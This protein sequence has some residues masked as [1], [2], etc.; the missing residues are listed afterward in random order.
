MDK[1]LEIN[2]QTTIKVN[3]INDENIQQNKFNDNVANVNKQIDKEKLLLEKDNAI[4]AFKEQLKMQD[5]F[6]V[7][8]NEEDIYQGSLQVE[9]IQEE[10]KKLEELEELEKR[11]IEFEKKLNSGKDMTAVSKEIIEGYIKNEY[12]DIEK[13][14]LNI[15]NRQEFIKENI[16][17]NVQTLNE[18]I[19]SYKTK[20]EKSID[21]RQK[22]NNDKFNSENIKISSKSKKDKGRKKVNTIKGK[23]I[24]ATEESAAMNYDMQHRMKKIQKW[25]KNPPKINDSDLGLT[26]NEFEIVFK[27]KSGSALDIK[28]VMEKIAL[29]DIKINSL[30]EMSD[31]KKKYLAYYNVLKKT[32]KVVCAA[33]GIDSDTCTY[34]KQDTAEEKEEVKK[35]VDFANSVYKNIMKEYKAAVY[36]INEDHVLDYKAGAKSKIKVKE[37]NEIKTDKEEF[38]FFNKTVDK[39]VKYKA[40]MTVFFG[41]IHRIRQDNANKVSDERW[42]DAVNM[43]RCFDASLYADLYER[44]EAVIEETKFLTDFANENYKEMFSFVNK[45]MV[46][47][48]ENGISLENAFD[49]QH[50]EKNISQYRQL[51]SIINIINDVRKQNGN[52]EDFANI[53]SEK[54]EYEKYKTIAE[55]SLLENFS[56]YIE[57]IAKF[58]SLNDREQ[59]LLLYK[60]HTMKEKMK[61]AGL[62]FDTKYKDVELSTVEFSDMCEISLTMD[63]QYRKTKAEPMYNDTV[64]ELNEY[65]EGLKKDLAEKE[66][67]YNILNSAV[68]VSEAVKLMTTGKLLHDKYSKKMNEIEEDIEEK[69]KLVE[70]AKKDGIPFSTVVQKNKVPINLAKTAM[71]K[72][73]KE[74]VVIDAYKYFQENIISVDDEKEKIIKEVRTKYGKTELDGLFDEFLSQKKVAYQNV[75]KIDAEKKNKEYELDKAEAYKKYKESYFELSSY[76]GT[77]E[78]EA[79][80]VEYFEAYSNYE[81]KFNSKTKESVK[82]NEESHKKNLIKQFKKMKDEDKQK[83]IVELGDVYIDIDNKQRDL[84]EFNSTFETKRMEYEAIAIA[85]MSKINLEIAD[86]IRFENLVKPYEDKR[87]EY[88]EE[89]DKVIAD[90][91]E[92]KYGDL[93][94]EGHVLGSIASEDIELYVNARKRIMIETNEYVR[95]M[96]EEAKSEFVSRYRRLEENFN[97][98]ELNKYEGIAEFNKFLKLFTAG[99]EL[100]DEVINKGLLSLKVENIKAKKL[101]KAINKVKSAIAKTEKVLKE[102]KAE[103]VSNYDEEAKEKSYKARKEK[104]DKCFTVVHNS[105]VTKAKKLAEK[106]LLKQESNTLGAKLLSEKFTKY[107]ERTDALIATKKDFNGVTYN[108]LAIQDFLLNTSDEKYLEFEEEYKNKKSDAYNLEEDDFKANVVDDGFASVDFKKLMYKRMKLMQ[109]VEAHKHLALKDDSD[110]KWYEKVY[111]RFRSFRQQQYDRRVERLEK[112]NKFIKLYCEVNGVDFE[113]GELLC[114]KVNLTAEEIEATVKEAS[115]LLDETMIDIQGSYFKEEEE[116]EE[117]EEGEE[118]EEKEKEEASGIIAMLNDKIDKVKKKIEEAQYEKKILKE[119]E[120]EVKDLELSTELYSKDLFKLDASAFKHDA[121]LRTAHAMASVTTKIAECKMACKVSV[122]VGKKSKEEKEAEN[123]ISQYGGGITVGASASF[124]ALSSEFVAKYGKKVLG[125]ETGAHV[126]GKIEIGKVAADATLQAGL[127]SDDGKFSPHVNLEAGIELALLKL[128]GSVGVKVLGVGVDAEL[129]FIA[130]LVGKANVSFKNWKLEVDLQAAIGIGFG[131][132]LSFDFADLKEKLVDKAKETATNVYN[133]VKESLVRS[134]ITYDPEIMTN[135]IMKDFSDGGF[136]FDADDND[137]GFANA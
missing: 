23:V 12:G 58:E 68:E 18:R 47:L 132:K 93:L 11:L 135:I 97:K 30:D 62:E 92:G 101:E 63:E 85:E 76:V 82:K 77:E 52:K 3:P 36:A 25:Y 2:K 48:N 55:L 53:F 80:W 31:E 107:K 127:R 114:D 67:E 69:K 137:V 37:Q 22:E 75:E 21:S 79:K 27:N 16:Q 117:E 13:E 43:C 123:E 61:N 104:N 49:K 41:A 1:Q 103:L 64:N 73:K 129:S 102:E 125:L 98:E 136:G 90:V 110:M 54:T 100:S 126:K 40:D 28:S 17:S 113:T 6:D 45:K 34:F 118:E 111:D 4:S 96:Y 131:V 66:K 7:G 35:K 109:W 121:K 14:K 46:S 59:K 134:G 108:T 89:Y 94:T 115:V 71:D 5:Q 105:L 130:G 88:L 19:T 95:R 60:G 33:N 70:A 120:E 99:G 56:E 116:E 84:D 26:G 39:D 74:T 9:K 51:A 20:I 32:L 87:I 38:K 81:V 50:V 29:L 112:I 86:K 72:A 78:W 8:I 42:N 106:Y 15:K 124:T 10:I 65:L 91:K 44:R 119:T 128:Q 57:G 133:Y 122:N 83:L 24:G